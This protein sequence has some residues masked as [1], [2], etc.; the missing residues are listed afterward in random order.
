MEKKKVKQKEEVIK[1]ETKK[2]PKIIY[3]IIIVLIIIVA[4]ILFLTNKKSDNNQGNGSGDE[5]TPFV[6]DS[7][8]ALS[9]GE[10]K[11]LEFLWIVDGAFNDSRFKESIKV[12]G[13]VMNDSDKKFVC[14]YEEGSDECLSKNFEEAFASVFASNL[15]YDD[16]YGD[17][18]A[19]RW[20]TKAG[21]DYFFK[22]INT[23][24]GERMSTDQKLEL[25]EET[26]DKITYKVSYTDKIA[27]GIFKGDHPTEKDFVLVK[28]GSNWKV[29]SAF[30][31]DPCYQSYNIP[32]K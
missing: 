4:L 20:Y 19:Y 32:R 13:K 9:L 30:Y 15:K 24:N 26:K 25:V 28:E 11:Y 21:D 16:I 8:N 10:G 3:I 27:F 14:N 1:K 2:N 22:N 31:H 29:S 12:N 23:C 17:G 5:G 6:P 18:L 7:D